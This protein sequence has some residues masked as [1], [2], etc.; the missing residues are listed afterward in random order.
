MSLQYKRQIPQINT[1]S[2]ELVFIERGSVRLTGGAVRI[3]PCEIMEMN[4]GR[5]SRD[6]IIDLNDPEIEVRRK[7]LE[8]RE[9]EIEDERTA[10]KARDAQTR[11]P[12]KHT[13]QKPKGGLQLCGMWGII[14][15]VF[16]L[17]VLVLVLWL[18]S[19]QD[20]N[21]SFDRPLIK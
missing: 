9:G 6:F 19:G 17:A 18:A 21:D 4:E 16:W 3:Y 20:G 10:R 7:R 2:T 14:V 13:S 11:L 12:Q 1:I 8:A 15:C 5:K